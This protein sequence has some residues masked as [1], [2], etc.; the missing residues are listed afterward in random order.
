MFSDR[1]KQEQP[2]TT[3]LF[4]AA[5]KSNRLVQAYLFTQSQA[6]VQYHFAMEL[7]KILNCSNKIGDTPCNNCTDC[8]WIN[9][10][11]HP[12]IITISPV[13]FVPQDEK[14]KPKIVSK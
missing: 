9:T 5:I 2:F 7:A 4:T 13:D 8:K 10:N 3:K 14:A 12:A 1:L 6:I 11:T